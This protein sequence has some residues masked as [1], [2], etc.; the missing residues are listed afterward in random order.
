MI[1]M[2]NLNFSEI[3]VD[4]NEPVLFGSGENTDDPAAQYPPAVHTGP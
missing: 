1:I 3:I 4:L 2:K